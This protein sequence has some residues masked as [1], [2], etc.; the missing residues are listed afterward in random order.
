[1]TIKSCIEGEADL[2]AFFLD[3]LAREYD[4]HQF[5]PGRLLNGRNRTM[6]LCRSR[7]RIVAAIDRRYCISPKGQSKE[8]GILSG[9]EERSPGW[10]ALPTTWLSRL[11]GMNDMTITSIRERIAKGDE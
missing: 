8:I 11:M 9:G 1:M 2:V 5:Q 6:D 10:R 4:D 3:L 7:E